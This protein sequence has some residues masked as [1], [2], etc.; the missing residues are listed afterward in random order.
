MRSDFPLI[1]EVPVILDLQFVVAPDIPMTPYGEDS[2]LPS[3]A[4]RVLGLG[5]KASS[6]MK[7]TEVPPV[8]SRSTT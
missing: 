5:I 6:T 4:I 2:K 1:E 3:E 8:I 7:L